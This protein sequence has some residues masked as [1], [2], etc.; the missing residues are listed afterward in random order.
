MFKL[1]KVG[2]W[3]KAIV[4]LVKSPFRYLFKPIKK[5]VGGWIKA[6]GGLEGGV[7]IC[8]K[9]LKRGWNRKERKGEKKFKKEVKLDQGVGALKWK[10]GWNPLTNYD[11][12]LYSR[13][14][15]KQGVLQQL[16]FEKNPGNFR[17][18]TLLKIS[19]KTKVHPWKLFN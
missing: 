18:L 12:G 7:G 2:W 11:V 5:F 9:N 17:F 6:E 13:K 4:E 19:D 3:L 15:N 8:L 14:K 1:R 10:G 16:L